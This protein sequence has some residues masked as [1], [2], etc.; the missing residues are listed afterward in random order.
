MWIGTFAASSMDLRIETSGADD[1]VNF[2]QY[3][4]LTYNASLGH[5]FDALWDEVQLVFHQTFQI[6]WTGRNTAASYW[7]S[8]LE[9]LENLWF[10]C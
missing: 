8:W 4:I 9:M 2:P 7:I 6:S 5:R 3:P 1:A 10:L